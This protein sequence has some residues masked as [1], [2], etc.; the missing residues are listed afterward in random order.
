[1]VPSAQS[2]Q[3]QVWTVTVSMFSV[4]VRGVW[5]M[6]LA[7]TLV[8]ELVPLSIA[9]LAQFPPLAFYCY[10]GAKLLTF[11]TFGFLTPISWWRY[12]TLGIGVLFAIVT[13]A[14]V[15]VG[16]GFIVG[17]RT[18]LLELA[19]KLTLLCTGFAGGL[20]IRKYQRLNLGPLTV[21]FSSRHWSRPA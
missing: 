1:M 21:R 13:T 14:I 5:F 17:H 16:Q 11:L 2:R 9:F 19:V 10:E 8:S 20:D 7:A 6:V 4:A 18:S 12:K 15:E 3:S